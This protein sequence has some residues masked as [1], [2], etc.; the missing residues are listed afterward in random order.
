[1][2]DLLDAQGQLWRASAVVFG[3]QIDLYTVRLVDSLAA[4]MRTQWAGWGAAGEGK[5]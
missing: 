2:G 5:E 4:D 3:E 1:V